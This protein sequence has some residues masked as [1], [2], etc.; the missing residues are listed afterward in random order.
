MRLRLTKR[1]VLKSSYLPVCNCC[2]PVSGSN[3]EVDVADCRC[4]DCVVVIRHVDADEEHSVQ[5]LAR[6]QT[7]QVGT[8]LTGR[9]LRRTVL[10]DST[11]S[12]LS[13]FAEFCE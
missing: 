8:E 13:T 7:A 3:A 12:S 10:L 2:G 9:Q 4:L 11:G 5:V 1:A 6:H